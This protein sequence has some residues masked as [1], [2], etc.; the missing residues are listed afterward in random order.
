MTT[1]APS[2]RLM[3]MTSGE[4]VLVNSASPDVITINLRDGDDVVIVARSEEHTSELQSHLNIVCRLLLEK[5]NEP[6]AADSGATAASAS[7]P[8]VATALASTVVDAAPPAPPHHCPAR[9]SRSGRLSKPSDA[10]VTS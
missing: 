10:V 8:P 3:V 5:K 9:S 7:A 1:S 2:R 6:A 4:T